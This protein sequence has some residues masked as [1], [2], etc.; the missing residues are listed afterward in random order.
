MIRVL[1]IKMSNLLSILIFLINFE[2]Y[3]DNKTERKKLLDMKGYR[4]MNICTFLEL[5]YFHKVHQREGYDTKV[6]LRP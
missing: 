6:T 5:I 1:E 3:Q 2:M 4:L